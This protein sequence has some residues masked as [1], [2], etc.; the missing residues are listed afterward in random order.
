MMKRNQKL[1]SANQLRKENKEQSHRLMKPKSMINVAY[2]IISHNAL[3]N[4]QHN[5][6]QICYTL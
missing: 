3:N 5:N 1:K 4:S 2:N 6:T